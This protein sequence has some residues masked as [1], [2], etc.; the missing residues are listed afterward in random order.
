MSRALGTLLVALAIAATAP[1]PDAARGADLFAQLRPINLRVIGG[2]SDWQAD[3]DFQL[4][5]DPP[6]VSRQDFEVSAV[7][8]RLHGAD[9]HTV[10]REIR[11]PWNTG[12]I[13]RIQVPP[14]PGAYVADVWLEGPAGETGPEVSATL[15]FD[16]VRPAPVQPLAP[17]GWIAGSIAAVLK[18]EHPAGPQP[19][20]GIRGYAVSVDR[21]AE[22]A[23]C[24]GPDRCSVAETDV[25]DGIGGDTVSLG[26][27]PNGIHVV[28]AV[29][30]SGSGMR[31]AEPR[32]TIV[33]VDSVPPSVALDGVPPGWSDRPVRLT[34]EAV[35]ASSGTAASGPNGP[36]VAIAV[37]GG[38]PRAELGASA[39]GV[40]SGEG[41]HD[42]AFYARDAAGNVSEDPLPVATVRIDESPPAVAFAGSQ[43]PSEPERIEAL[44]ADALSGPDP[45]RGSIQLR[46]A[47]SRARFVALPTAVSAGRLVARWD[48]DAFPPGTY[49][50][51][52]TGYDA[53][54]NAAA[55]ERRGNGTRMVLANPLKRRAEIVAGFGGRRQVRQRCSR[56]RGR[57]RCRREAI[58]AFE[59]RPTI[60]LVAYGH[61]I[62]YSGRLVS[63]S[64]SGLGGLPIEVVETFD[65]GAGSAQRTTEVQTA[66]DGTFQTRLSPGPSRQVA[67]FFAGNRTTT[68]AGGGEVRLQV[69]G[70]VCLHASTASAQIGGAPAVF[71]GRVGD[72]EAPLPPGGRP[73][74]LQF[75]IPG[76]EWSEFRTV[77]S[78]ARGRFRY[79]YSFSDDDSRGVRFQFRAHLPAQDGWPYEPAASRPLFITGR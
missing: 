15:R 8:Y 32:S 39:A 17:A 9:G 5:W 67:A 47:G 31:S 25:R 72:L 27:L 42:V 26:F 30:V 65:A 71:S 1:P 56:E 70:G 19:I 23:P 49:E 35:D 43:D 21:G 52:A 66:P 74:E 33:R 7:N 75:R 55:S 59:Y 28:R 50:F 20:S 77:Q 60:R 37:D 10:V 18:M 79:A 51:R 57:Q 16:D 45:R 68:R 34:A 78:D 53:A 58:D 24:A 12:Q 46:P 64:G 54:G 2:E 6:L 13:D 62:R 11:F 38:V 44:V 36:F 14:A 22:S 29:A 73:V 48:S 61:G 76:G 41:V 69:L 4:A 40:V 63:P 3:N